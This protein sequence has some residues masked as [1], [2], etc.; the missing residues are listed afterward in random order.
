VLHL[1]KIIL[2]NNILLEVMGEI[3]FVTNMMTV[4]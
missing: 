2:E 4:D 3:V 1:F